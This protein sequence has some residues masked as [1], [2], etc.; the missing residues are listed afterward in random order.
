MGRH[1]LNLAPVVGIIAVLVVWTASAGGEALAAQ[2][3][4][5]STALRMESTGSGVELLWLPDEPGEEPS[6]GEPEVDRVFSARLVH[7]SGIRVGVALN[8]GLCYAEIGV[9]FGNMWG[10]RV[11]AQSRPGGGAVCVGWIEIGEVPPTVYSGC[12]RGDTE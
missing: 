10:A 5:T 2:E 9:G 4:G 12:E 11:G 3:T 8:L 6:C 7:G 1:L